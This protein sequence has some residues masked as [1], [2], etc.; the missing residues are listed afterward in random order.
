[1]EALPPS[2]SSTG[3]M[4]SA[5]RFAAMRPTLVEPVKLIR[6][7]A[8]MIDQG[9]DDLAGI[10]RRVDLTK[11][12][13]ARRQPSAAKGFRD[14]FVGARANL[15]PL[16]HNG[17]AARQRR[18]DGADAKDHRR[19]PRS[20]AQH[21]ARRPWRIDMAR[22]PGLSDGITSPPIWVGRALRPRGSFRS[23]ASR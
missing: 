4:C 15:R 6:R 19:V 1:M 21:H 23:P 12:T 16:E 8:G 13:T 10:L 22:Q 14:Q 7:T 17:V 20:N 11:R 3:F 9:A 5:A 2:S 18:C